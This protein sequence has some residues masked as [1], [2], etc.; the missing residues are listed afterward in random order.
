MRPP[1][2]PRP[3]SITTQVHFRA[4]RKILFYRLISS[5]VSA[6]VLVSALVQASF[7]SQQRFHFL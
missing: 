3:H 2:R 4:F 1:H 6:K 7:G 5:L